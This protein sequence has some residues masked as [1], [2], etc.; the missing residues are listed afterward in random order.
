MRCL[1]GLAFAGLTAVSGCV[2]PGPG[3]AAASEIAI[4]MNAAD[5]LLRAGC[6]DCLAAALREYDSMAARPRLPRAAAEAAASGAVRA[7]L[8]LAI[9]ERELGFPRP[10]YSTRARELVAAL[11]PAGARFEELLEA[12]DVLR[13][14]LVSPGADDGMTPRRRAFREAAPAFLAARR[15]E[16]DEDPLSA[17]AWVAFTCAY[18]GADRTPEALMAPLVRM[19]ASPLVSY[20]AATC[21]DIDGAALEE[22]LRREP[23][24]AEANFWLGQDAIGR[25]RLEEA[26][27]RLTRAFAWRGE[28]PAVTMALGNV[29]GALEEPER[30]LEYYDRTLALA[31]G[32]AEALIGRVRALSLLGRNEEA[33][34]A[35]D[36]MLGAASRVL[37]GEAYYWR[38]W[39]DLQMGRLDEA[40]TDIE[41]AAPLWVNSE[42]SKL[43]GLVAYRRGDLATAAARFEAARRLM[44]GDCGSAYYLGIVHADRRDWPAMGDV[45]AAAAACLEAARDALRRD[46]GQAPAAASD[47]AARQRA[48]RATQLAETDRQLATSWFN[49]AVAYFNLSRAEEARQYAEKVL[50]DP[51]YA[52]RAGEL[53]DRLEGR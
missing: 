44:P 7:A 48:R 10:E 15:A 36:A 11:G 31:P 53:L 19:R 18:G 28:W 47:R 24:F 16:A 38:A 4:R 40:W 35:A 12:A 42:V 26:E 6:F 25:L 34:A 39:N 37:P 50:G 23:R 45:F 52:E 3:A 21:V 33:I 2:R 22:V 41:Q 8:L 32:A 43:G 5:E 1:A 29:Y 49:T 51:Q 46:V 27:A 13:S 9:R 30:A 20:R 14:P 17:Y